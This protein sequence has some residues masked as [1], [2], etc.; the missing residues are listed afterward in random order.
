MKYFDIGGSGAGLVPLHLEGGERG[1]GGED[2][3]H[4]I[5]PRTPIIYLTTS[6]RTTR[7]NLPHAGAVKSRKSVQAGPTRDKESKTN[8]IWPQPGPTRDRESKPTR[9]DHNQ[10]QPE[11]GKAKTNRY[12]H[13]QD[14]TGTE[15]N[16]RNQ[17]RPE[18]RPQP[19]P[20]RLYHNSKT[21]ATSRSSQRRFNRDLQETSNK[22][23]IETSRS[24]TI[25]N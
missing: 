15:K 25:A 16:D 12:D 4:F 5:L 6:T 8:Q 11:I 22:D 13:N 9:Y 3:L 14:Q 10:D 23:Q 24:N 2:W 1:G 17:D 20:Y 7:A 19:I 21:T 18:I